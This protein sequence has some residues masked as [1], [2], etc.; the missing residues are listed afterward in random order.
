MYHYFDDKEFLHKMRSLSGD[1]MQLVCHYL[2]EDYDI[3]AN[4]CLV[5]SGARNLIL[6]NEKKP[7]DLDYNL[8]IVR[9]N[10][11]ED[12][13]YLKECARKTFNKV[14]RKYRLHDC[15]DSTSSLTSK[16]IQIGSDS[17]SEFHIDICITTRDKEDNCYRLIHEK[18]GWT[19][20]DRY[21]WNMARQSKSLKKKVDYIKEHGKWE[22]VREQYLRIKNRYL[23][24]NDHDHPSFICYVEAVNNAYNS[25]NHW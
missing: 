20:T 9:C 14:L 10:D 12:C 11:Y 2:K 4:F 25:R 8:E 7:V 13:R 17:D 5:G 23:T 21:F 1:I 6:Q 24:E 15:E 16:L 22:L 19:Y 3:G 18:N